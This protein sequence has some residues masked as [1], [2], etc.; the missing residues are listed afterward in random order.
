[1]GDGGT[2]LFLR[3]TCRWSISKLRDEGATQLMIRFERR[4]R[5]SS[6]RSLV[7]PCRIASFVASKAG[8]V[9]RAR[10]MDVIEEILSRILFL[11]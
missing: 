1:M 5:C 10:S 2:L 9:R 3:A 11:E 6:R 4:A 7:C 8:A